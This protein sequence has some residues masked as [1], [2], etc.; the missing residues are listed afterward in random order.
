M[1]LALYVYDPLLDDPFNTAEQFQTKRF[2][3]RSKRGR[4]HAF[5]T[6]KCPKC[7]RR[8]RLHWFMGNYRLVC[9]WCGDESY[10]PYGVGGRPI[11]W[12]GIS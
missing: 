10:P 1:T 9:S 11:L 3:R 8:N 7:G 12:E 5:Y 4:L 6:A 2:M